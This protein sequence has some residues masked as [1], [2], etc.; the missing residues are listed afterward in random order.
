MKP[1]LTDTG[2]QFSP[3]WPGKPPGMSPKDR[4]IWNRYRTLHCTEWEKVYYNVRVGEGTIPTDNINDNVA[5]GWKDST[6]LRI[7]AVVETKDEIIL[8]EVR[9]HANKGVLGAALTYRQLWSEDPVI[10]K[11]FRFIVIT[12]YI[13]PELQRILRMHDVNSHVV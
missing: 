6:Q 7:D 9:E 3:L 5:K 10:P 2:I 1:G 8:I 4:S 12:D 13:T 11:P